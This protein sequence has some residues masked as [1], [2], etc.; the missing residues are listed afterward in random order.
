[1]ATGFF[2]SEHDEFRSIVHDFIDREVVQ[3]YARWEE[4]G[5]ID[6]AL[7]PAAAALGL[8]G[9]EVGPEHG[10]MGVADWRFRLVV[11]EELAS[12]GAAALNTALAAQDDLVVPALLRLG[13]DEQ[14]ARW[15]PGMAAGEVIG[16]VAFT[17]PGAGS[18]L[19]AMRASAVRD[20]DGW[21][22][23]GQKAFVSNGLSAGVLVVAAVTASAD[24][25]PGHTL[26]LVDGDQ[27]GVERGRPLA[28]LGLHAQDTVEVFFADC[29][30]TADQ[31]LGEV[32]AGMAEIAML[33]PRERLAQAAISWAEARAALDWAG[34]HVFARKAFGTLLGD[35]QNTRFT[36]AETET[37]LD[38][39]RSYLQQ[40]VLDLNADGLT[41]VQ[42]AK[43]KY[44]AGEQ[45]TSVVSRMLQLFGGYGFME[46]YPIARAY[47][48][49]RVQT[50]Y[51]GTTEVMKEIIG[52]DIARRHRRG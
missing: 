39:T 33:L 47:R 24:G 44:W 40:C 25:T 8:L 50:I 16:A 31:V 36:L 48:D 23:N 4:A 26:F 6:P 37:G 11:V 12:A 30:L 1:M 52:R 10:G 21:V 19:R 43:A 15:L 27:E 38:V 49:C 34:E 3:H 2:E 45:A 13:T 7:W 41:G 9:L 42:A 17:E 18:D 28:K 22:L 5:R 29:R 35:L 14:R 20:G 51:A 32:G 46:E